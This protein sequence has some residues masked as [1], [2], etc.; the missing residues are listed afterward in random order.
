MCVP[1]MKVPKRII[2]LEHHP[3]CYGNESCGSPIGGNDDILR[4]NEEFR[5]AKTEFETGAEVQTEV[6]LAVDVLCHRLSACRGPSGARG[7]RLYA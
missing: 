1:F 5:G 6:G 2:L 3:D 7:D 4:F